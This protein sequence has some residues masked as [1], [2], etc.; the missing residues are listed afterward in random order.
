MRG[1]QNLAMQDALMEAFKNWRKEKAKNPKP[2]K[3]H[4][5]QHYTL[6]V[7]NKVGRVIEKKNKTWKIPKITLGGKEWKL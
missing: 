7:K 3:P 1:N 4:K 2:S 5:V 6:T